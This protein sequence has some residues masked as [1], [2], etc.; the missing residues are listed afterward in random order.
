MKAVVIKDEW[1]PCYSLVKPTA[2]DEDVVEVDNEFYQR[3]RELMKEFA[4][5]QKELENLYY[6][7]EEEIDD[8][9]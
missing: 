4:D 5:L 2:D 3:C 9:D 6:L 8:D 7:E 1:Y